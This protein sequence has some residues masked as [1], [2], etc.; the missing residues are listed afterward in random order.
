[1][2][3]TR[4]APS[5]MKRFACLCAALAIWLVIAAI[6]IFTAIGIVHA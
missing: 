5:V 3:P 1:M 4:S 2:T 6:V